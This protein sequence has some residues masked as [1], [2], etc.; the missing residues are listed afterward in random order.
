L[1]LLTEDALKSKTVQEAPK[2]VKENHKDSENRRLL[3]A[4]D[5]GQEVLGEVPIRQYVVTIPK[6]L[7]LYFKYDR[8]LLGELSRCLYES[9]KEMFLAAD[10]SGERRTSD[11]RALPGMVSSVQ[12]YGE[13]PSRFHPHVHSLVADGLLLPDGGF[14]PIPRPDPVQIML[15]FRHKLLKSLLAEQ[16]I[17][18]RLIDILLSWRH[19]GFSV[20]QGEP[21]APQDHDTRQ[22][23]ARYCV[24]APIALDRLHYDRR[25]RQVVYDGKDHK[26]SPRSDAAGSE[27]CAALDFLAALCTHIPDAGQQLIRYYGAWSHVRRARGRAV[28][29][30]APQADASPQELE[31]D[32]VCGEQEARRLRSAWARLV[33]KVY[34]ADPLICRRCG[35]RLK[36]IAL[37]DSASI[38]ERM[39]RHLKLWARPQRPPPDPP[40]RSL[41][42]DPEFVPSGD[43]DQR[44]ATGE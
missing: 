3:F 25:S 12:T 7:R 41:A 42:Y 11:R 29:A 9:I 38:I 6:M 14:I 13:D 21:V 27:V 30:Q 2:T 36:I 26:G 10:P 31:K 15:L 33:K 23:L 22:R 43:V 28:C 32:P 44:L 8:K 34:E 18:H 16:K 39:L 5:V 20:F 1:H 35:G 17:S 37:I 4:E 40:E 19:P 24:H